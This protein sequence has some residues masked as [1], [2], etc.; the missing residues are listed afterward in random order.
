MGLY[1]FPNPFNR[2]TRF[3]NNIRCEVPDVLH[4]LPNF[5]S[6]VHAGAAGVFG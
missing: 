2:L 3:G 4:A 6:C 1:K 5:E